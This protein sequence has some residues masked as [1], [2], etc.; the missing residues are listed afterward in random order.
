MGLLN[1]NK[2]KDDKKGTAKAGKAG[3]QA[4]K[5]LNKNVNSGGFAKKT[6][7]GSAN[8]GS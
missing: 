4:S 8:R 7:P 3:G 2:K 6:K 1:Q 5:F